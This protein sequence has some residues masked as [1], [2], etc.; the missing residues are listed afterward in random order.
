MN[1]VKTLF[2]HYCLPLAAL[3]IFLFAVT[4]CISQPDTTEANEHEVSAQEKPDS[5]ES[6][7]GEKQESEKSG[8]EER[9]YGDIVIEAAHEAEI[10]INDE[11]RI[12]IS[13]NGSVYLRNM[14][15]GTYHIVITYPEGKSESREITVVGNQ[16]TLVRFNWKPEDAG[17]TPTADKP[18]AS[19]KD[20]AAAAD[21]SRTSQMKEGA[22]EETS[23]SSG[24]ESSSRGDKAS[25]RDDETRVVQLPDGEYVGEVEN[26]QLHGHGIFR[27]DNGNV[28]RGDWRHGKKHGFGT[29]RW[30]D[31]D[32]YKGEWKNDQ[33]HGTGTYTLANG[34]TYTGSWK[35]GQK[36]GYG[37]YTWENGDRYEGHWKNDEKEGYGIFTSADGSRYE[38]EW[39]NDTMHGKG[40]FVWSDGDKYSGEWKNG[41]MHGKGTFSIAYRGYYEGEFEDG[42]AIGGWYYPA[43]GKKRWASMNEEGEWVF[44]DKPP[45]EQ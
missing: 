14:D 37:V 16:T 24:K 8:Q 41:V 9:I 2:S 11:E 15:E 19:E 32:V 20:M 4:S 28:Y 7:P 34:D 3:L 23:P 10:T 25:T 38:G 22:T 12:P 39:K 45:E 30:N 13:E 21:E 44:D 31:G 36:H 35:E 43:D 5:R 6:T 26:K 42:R 33:R 27:A 1:H 29:Y 18:P 17:S 40:T